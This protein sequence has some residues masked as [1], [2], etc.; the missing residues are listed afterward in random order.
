MALLPKTRM[1]KRMRR[2]FIHEH[3]KNPGQDNH[4]EGF[5]GPP[6]L[7]VLSAM[8]STLTSLFMSSLM[9]G[10]IGSAD[11][12]G[13]ATAQTRARRHGD[14]SNVLLFMHFFCKKGE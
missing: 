3:Q 8:F 10:G 6:L 11:S 14:G 13:Q 7:A 5:A 2:I 1:K 12:S 9:E 4:S